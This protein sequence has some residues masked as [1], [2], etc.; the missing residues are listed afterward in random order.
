MTS[1]SCVKCALETIGTLRRT[2]QRAGWPE[3]ILLGTS[4]PVRD[5]VWTPFG[6]TG[7]NT[8]MIDNDGDA[9]G[10]IVLV[11]GLWALAALSAIPVIR[12]RWLSSRRR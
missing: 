10:N 8:D 9:V 12:L 4:V 1:C 3:V 6:A 11:V 5:R 2:G 7:S